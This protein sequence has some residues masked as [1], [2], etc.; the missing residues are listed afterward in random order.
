MYVCLRKR[1][2]TS[3]TRQVDAQTVKQLGLIATNAGLKIALRLPRISAAKRRMQLLALFFSLN[4]A[5]RF[6]PFLVFND[7]DVCWSN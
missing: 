2:L 3:R 1:R 6:A 4:D 5:L 7:V